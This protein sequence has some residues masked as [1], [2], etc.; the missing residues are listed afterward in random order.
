M[1]LFYARSVN[2]LP[3]FGIVFFVLELGRLPY[4]LF[5]VKKEK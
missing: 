4:F 3:F 2:I 5:L 1:A